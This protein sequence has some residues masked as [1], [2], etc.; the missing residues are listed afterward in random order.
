LSA[1]AEH[2][3]Q[4]FQRP[5]RLLQLGYQDQRGVRGVGLNA[6]RSRAVFQRSI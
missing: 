4:G 3:A 6:A 2:P 1:D 5:Q